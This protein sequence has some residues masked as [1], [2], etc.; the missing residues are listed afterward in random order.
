LF[1]L[2]ALAFQ[3]DLTRVFTFMMGREGS[4]R[5]YPEIGVRDAHHP[6]T[7]TY[8]REPVMKVTKINMYH[9]ELF[10]YFL[11]KLRSTPDGDGSLLDHSLLV[12]GAGISDGNAHTH[13]NVP[14]MLAG[15]A[16]GRITGGRHI[17]YSNE[18]PLANLWLTL[19]DNLNVDA[20]RVGESTGRLDGL[21]AV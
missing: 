8:E 20:E 12:Y 19:L 9:V 3:C 15:H 1:D 2:Q 18:P 5:S 11:E 14:V 21:A 10:A 7:H 13:E 4:R 17:R 16:G 6:L